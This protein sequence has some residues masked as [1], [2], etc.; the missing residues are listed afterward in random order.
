MFPLTWA[1]TPWYVLGVARPL[2]IDVP[3]GLYHMARE[4]TGASLVGLG[5]RYGGVRAQAVSAA[6]WQFAQRAGEDRGLARKLA[7]C[8][9]RVREQWTFGT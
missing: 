4:L 6:A 7:A 3:D 8:E 1:T 5:E 9:R 2:R